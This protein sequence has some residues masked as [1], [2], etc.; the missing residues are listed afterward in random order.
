MGIVNKWSRKRPRNPGSPGGS[1]ADRDPED[2]NSGRPGAGR[3]R[4]EHRL[5]LVPDAAA[6]AA[7]MLLIACDAPVLSVLKP[8][9]GFSDLI[10]RK[11]Q[12]VRSY[13]EAL[14]QLERQAALVVENIIDNLG[15]E[16]SPQS[17]PILH[18]LF[19]IL[20]E[21]AL[22]LDDT[23]A[24]EAG[25]TRRKFKY[26]KL[27]LWLTAGHELDRVR[28]LSYRLR[29]AVSVLGV[30]LDSTCFAS[31]DLRMAC[32]LRPRWNSTD[33]QVILNSSRPQNGRRNLCSN[34]T[35]QA[36]LLTCRSS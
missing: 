32:R 29:D 26:S 20:D 18:E 11:L 19:L 23:D 14:N 10:C 28:D 24:A 21:V 9:A 30:S 13:K 7:K 6:L 2:E 3:H 35:S 8:V 12:I 33:P 36:L 25:A 22:S 5:T 34:C 15:D 17:Q 16:V 31:Y 4:V 27:K 1:S